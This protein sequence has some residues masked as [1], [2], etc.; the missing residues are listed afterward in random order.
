ML[1]RSN[2]TVGASPWLCPSFPT[3]CPHRVRHGRIPQPTR[4]YPRLWIDRPS[5]GRSRDFN[6]PDQDAAQHTLRRL[7]D[8]GARALQAIPRSVGAERIERD[9]GVPFIPLNGVVLHRPARRR[10]PIAKT[11]RSAPGALRS[12]HCGSGCAV[13]PL[14]IGIQAVELSPYHAGLAGPCLQCLPTSPASRAC[15]F[16]LRL[17]PSG[18][19]DDPETSLRVPPD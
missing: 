1:F 3:S 11:G 19:P 10:E 15:S 5:F 14:E 12:R 16:P 9:L 17:S 4:H 7:R 13:P 6:P 2:A 18:Q 8:H